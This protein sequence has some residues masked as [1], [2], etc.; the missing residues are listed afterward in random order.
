MLILWKGDTIYFKMLVYL[1]MYIYC[2]LRLSYQYYIS[3]V[4]FQI[5]KYNLNID[6][7][8]PSR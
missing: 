7:T 8:T 5:I 1:E 2:T 4:N 3:P 6:D